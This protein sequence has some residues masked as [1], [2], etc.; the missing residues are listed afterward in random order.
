MVNL[1]H[2][3][4]SMECNCQRCDYKWTPRSEKPARCPR[5][6]ST[7]WDEAPISHYCYRCGFRWTQ[8]GDDTP[9]FCP[10][11]HS[12]VWMQK[13]VVYVCPRCG[14]SRTLR[15]NSRSQMCPYCDSYDDGR[16]RGDSKTS[17]DLTGFALVYDDPSL[18]KTIYYEASTEKLVLYSGGKYVSSGDVS[19]W[20]FET[21]H[22]APDV[23][24]AQ[25]NK[26]IAK[27][28]LNYLETNRAENDR[29]RSRETIM[30]MYRQGMNPISIAIALN[31]AYSDVTEIIKK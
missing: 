17:R 4:K 10:S 25:K 31:M 2:R 18:N 9:R 14:K 26:E 7:K 28:L 21:G 20:S 12:Y 29:D 1:H 16:D 8:R 11:C 6:K 30:K 5:C 24:H 15:S 3:G 13:K 27:T 23:H 22:P 19:R